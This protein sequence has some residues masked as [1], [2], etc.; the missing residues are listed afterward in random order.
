MMDGSCSMANNLHY[1]QMYFSLF[2]VEENSLQESLASYFIDRPHI[3]IKINALI[4]LGIQR[5]Q[6]NQWRSDLV[7]GR[8]LWMTGLRMLVGPNHPCTHMLLYILLVFQLH[9]RWTWVKKKSGEKGW[10]GGRYNKTERDG[11]S[12]EEQRKGGTEMLRKRSLIW[13]YWMWREECGRA[14]ADGREEKKSETTEK[15]HCVYWSAAARCFYFFLFFVR[16][17]E[18]KGGKDERT[19]LLCLC[20]SSPAERH[21]TGERSTLSL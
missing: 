14:I 8:H 15:H 1:F 16:R 17:E 12:A 6:E 11:R 3:I 20:A 4:L 21:I 9:S 5:W 2:S 19:A 18:A 13:I 7:R 10:D